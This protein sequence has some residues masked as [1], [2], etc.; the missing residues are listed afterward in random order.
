M[1]V[2]FTTRLLAAQE[3]GKLFVVSM[4]SHGYCGL[5]DPA[6]LA[7]SRNTYLFSVLQ[8]SE[9]LWLCFVSRGNIKRKKCGEHK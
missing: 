6:L 2:Q 4:M 9:V 5:S 8:I 1:S 3:V 7:V